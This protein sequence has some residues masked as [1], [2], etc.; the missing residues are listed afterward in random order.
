M[1]QNNPFHTSFFLTASFPY[2]SRNTPCRKNA[3]S[4]FCKSSIQNLF[5]RFFLFTIFHSSLMNMPIIYIEEIETTLLTL[6][7]RILGFIGG[8]VDSALNNTRF[9]TS[10]SEFTNFQIL[11]F[12]LFQFSNLLEVVLIRRKKLPGQ[13]PDS[14]YKPALKIFIPVRSIFVQPC[15][16]YSRYLYQLAI[17]LSCYYNTL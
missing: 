1:D 3:P 9:M 4:F 13:V 12:Q 15:L 17:P 14:T 2:I 5:S 6:F 10:P 11:N 8:K 16:C 7:G